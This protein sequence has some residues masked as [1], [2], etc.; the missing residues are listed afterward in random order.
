MLN[1]SSVV[2]AVVKS[3]NGPD[4]LLDIFLKRN[5][6]RHHSGHA[7]VLKLNTGRITSIVAELEKLYE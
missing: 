1:G 7:V 5:G 3:H 6:V 2:V 4:N